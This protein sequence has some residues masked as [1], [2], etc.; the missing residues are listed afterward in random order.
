VGFGEIEGNLRFGSKLTV[1]VQIARSARKN[2]L[3]Q[4]KELNEEERING[5]GS[6]DQ[7]P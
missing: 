7:E 3:D 1:K 4:T 6:G 5:M 2:S